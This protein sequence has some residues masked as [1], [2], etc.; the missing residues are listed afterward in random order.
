MWADAKKLIKSEQAE[1]PIYY[2]FFEKMVNRLL[3]Y[4]R[5]RTGTL[6]LPTEPEIEEIYAEESHLPIGSPMSRQKR[7]K[8]PASDGRI[9][10]A[11]LWFAP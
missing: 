4:D 3:E 6:Q 11:G 2:E 9:A 5:P 7:S 8:R 10:F 1:N